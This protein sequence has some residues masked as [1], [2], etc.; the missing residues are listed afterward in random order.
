MASDH[1]PWRPQLKDDHPDE[2]ARRGAH[3]DHGVERPPEEREGDLDSD[4]LGERSIGHQDPG[5]TSS[6]LLLSVLADAAAAT[7]SADSAAASA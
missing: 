3:E 1:G 7:G 6:A 5:A 4:S 2:N